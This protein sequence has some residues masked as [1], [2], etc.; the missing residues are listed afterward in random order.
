MDQTQGLEKATFL[1]DETR[2]RAFVRSLEI[3]GEAVKQLPDAVKQRYSHLEWR[4]MAGMRDRLIHGYFGVD[5][6]CVGCRDQQNPGVT[7]GSHAH[8]APR[9]PPLTASHGVIFAGAEESGLF[10]GRTDPA[11][12]PSGSDGPQRRL[13]GSACVSACGPPLTG[14]DIM[15]VIS[16]EIFVGCLECVVNEAR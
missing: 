3:I 14:R 12:Q 8:P 7:A 11:E 5:Y 2:K 9:R 1:C 10:Y 13:F 6:D 4:A 15:A 16:L